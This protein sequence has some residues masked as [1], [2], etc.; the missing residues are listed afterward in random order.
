MQFNGP[1]VP[2]RYGRKLPPIPPSIAPRIGVSVAAHRRRIASHEIYVL[3]RTVASVEGT[4]IDLCYVDFGL[5]MNADITRTAF[6][7][8]LQALAPPTRTLGAR[9]HSVTE[10]DI[11]CRRCGTVVKHYY[12]DKFWNG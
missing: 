11:V 9:E 3:P 5:D 10:W 12:T 2:Y 7:L 1:E 4:E 8:T 6:G